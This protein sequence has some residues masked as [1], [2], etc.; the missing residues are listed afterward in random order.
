MAKAKAVSAASTTKFVYVTRGNYAGQFLQMDESM[1]AA[2]NGDQWGISEFTG[3]R[4]PNATG[5]DTTIPDGWETGNFNL[6]QSLTDFQDSIVP[7]S[8]DP[9]DGPGPDPEPEPT[10]EPPVLTSLDP[11]TAEIGGADITMS[12]KGSNFTEETRIVFGGGQEN[13]VFVSDTEVTTI[14][15]PSTAEVAVSVPVFVRTGDLESDPLDF[16][17]TEADDE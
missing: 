1:A 14:V 15:K 4:E 8:P 6:P 9:D 11:A 5:F 7:V 12:A 17:F 13:T 10:P 3:D 2:A 16:T